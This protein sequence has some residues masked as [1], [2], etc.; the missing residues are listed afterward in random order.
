MG[1]IIDWI[2]SDSPKNRTDLSHAVHAD[3]CNILP[4]GECDKSPPAFTWRDYSAILYLNND[5]DG[6]EFIFS[7]DPKGKTIQVSKTSKSNLVDH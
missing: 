6:G 4:D 1:R 2:V 7:E 3:N 5:F